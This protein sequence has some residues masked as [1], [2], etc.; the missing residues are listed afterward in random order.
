MGAI[1]VANST[2]TIW[3]NARVP[4]EAKV[5]LRAG[6]GENR[7]IFADETTSAATVGANTVAVLSPLPADAD[8]A[9]GQPDPVEVMGSERLRWVH[10]NSAGYTRYDRD[11]LRAGGHVSAQIDALI[12]AR[13]DVVAARG[14]VRGHVT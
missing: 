1:S 8:I 3:C 7:I 9:F 12:A 10:L 4:T 11:D 6:I 13:D 2:L 5:S 14:A